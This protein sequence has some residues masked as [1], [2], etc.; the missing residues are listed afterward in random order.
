MSLSGALAPKRLKR[1]YIWKVEEEMQYT[2]PEALLS[3]RSAFFRAV[4]K[5][6]FKEAMEKKITLPE[7]NSKVFATY[8]Q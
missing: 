4:L 5:G 1:V 3:R 6:E 7:V 2:I 8:A